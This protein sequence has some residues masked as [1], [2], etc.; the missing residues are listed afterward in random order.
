MFGAIKIT[1][2]ANSDHNKY[3]GYGICFDSSTDFTFGNI[4]N[5]KN[6]IMFGS[7]MSFNAHERN[8]ANKIYVLGRGEI[9]GVTTVGPT[10]NSGK[11]A[12]KKTTEISVEELY[13]TNFTE[14]DK[15]IVLSLR[16]NGDSFYLIVNGTEQLKFKTD[17]KETQKLSLTLDNKSPVWSLTNSTKTGFFGGVYDFAVDSINSGGTI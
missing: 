1:K 6:V 7:D 16:Y 8:R 14:P 10:T 9:Q 2:D 4:T 11:T 13:K 5:G 17:T 15:K 12:K 3:S